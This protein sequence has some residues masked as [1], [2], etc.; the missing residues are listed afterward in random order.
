MLTNL[1]SSSFQARPPGIYKQ[2]YLTELFRR[3]GDPDDT[4]PAPALPDWCSGK[5]QYSGICLERPPCWP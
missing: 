5:T 4:P 2:D 1:P 3:Y